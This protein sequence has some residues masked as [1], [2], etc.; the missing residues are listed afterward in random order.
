MLLLGSCPMDC[1]LCYLHR[2]RYCMVQ[3]LLGHASISTTEHY[4]HLNNQEIATKNLKHNPL[5]NLNLSPIN[6]DLS[7][8][9]TD[10][11]PCYPLFNSS[12]QTT[13]FYISEPGTTSALASQALL[14]LS[15][16][17]QPDSTIWIRRSHQNSTFLVGKYRNSVSNV[18]LQRK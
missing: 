2:L 1:F 4:C 16:S 7:P 13:T 6:I 17:L 3:K 18:V 12:P 11:S 15:T 5:L 10:L 9:E 14:V 8:N